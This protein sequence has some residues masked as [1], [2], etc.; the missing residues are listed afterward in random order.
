MFLNDI[1]GAFDR[2][3]TK[4]L[5]AKMRRL[6]ICETLMAFF[7]D[8]LA[9]R[10]ARVAVDGAESFAFVVLNMVFQGTVLGPTFWNIFFADVH[11][12]AKRNGAKQPDNNGAV[13]LLAVVII[14]IIIIIAITVIMM[15]IAIRIIQ[16]I[17]LLQEHFKMK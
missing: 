12:L 4:K 15:V 16:N 13:I 1:S 8:Y 17:I 5:L 2:V 14:V 7:E 9:P 11:E 3:D 10:S 6:G